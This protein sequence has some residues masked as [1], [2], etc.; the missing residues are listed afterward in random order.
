LHCKNDNVPTDT[1]LSLIKYEF[2]KKLYDKIDYSTCM[3]IKRYTKVLSRLVTENC[4][5]E[6]NIR[7]VALSCGI[8]RLNSINMIKH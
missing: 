1:T 2:N 8:A 7:D 6:T 3:S 4:P 5:T